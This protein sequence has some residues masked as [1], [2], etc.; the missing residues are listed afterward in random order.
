MNYS[1]IIKKLAGFAMFIGFFLVL[2]GVG[3]ADFADETHKQ[4]TFL[5]YAPPIIIGLVLMIP[6]FYMFQEYEEDENNG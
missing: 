3:T 2:G 6:G 4:I 5:E 1:K